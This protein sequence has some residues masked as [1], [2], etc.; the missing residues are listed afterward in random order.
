MRLSKYSFGI[1]DRFARQGRAQLDAI[2]EARKEGV[3]I[4]PVWNKSFREHHIIGSSPKETRE[5]A[6]RAV[7]EAEWDQAYFVDADHIGMSNVDHFLDFSDYFTIDVADHIGSPVQDEDVE[8]F[9]RENE[10]LTGTLHIEGFSQPSVIKPDEIRES[11]A[12]FLAAVAEVEKVYR[13][14]LKHKKRYKIAIEISM[15]EVEQP[16]SPSELL[17]ILKMLAD[18]DVHPNTIAVKFCGQFNKGVD[19]RGDIDRFAREFE[20][21]L[22][23]IDFATRKFRLPENLKLSIHSGSD[24]FSLYRPIHNILKRHNR[25]IHVKTAGTTWLEELIG[26]LSAGEEGVE[27]VKKIFGN[28]LQRREELT[29]RYRSV[30]DIDPAMLPERKE[31]EKWSGKKL[32]NMLRHN[33][34]HP[35]YNPQ[36]RQLLHCAYKIAAEMGEQ[37]TDAL[38]KHEPVIAPCVKENLYERH[39]RPLFLGG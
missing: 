23:V 37:F 20:Q 38:E 7:K 31:I 26:L 9:V 21:H 2:L 13:Y 16:Q 33:P 35:E 34:D 27:I 36:V 14:I 24:K 15:D 3:L 11:A 28:A 30:T 18:R 6:D 4:T 17:L 8:R 19:Y 10:E 29:A 1:G 32:V 5:E 25:G 39:I 22:L 12:K